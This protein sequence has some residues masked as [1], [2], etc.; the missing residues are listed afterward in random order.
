MHPELGL[1]EEGCGEIYRTEWSSGVAVSCIKH[2]EACNIVKY[3]PFGGQY[4]R[5]FRQLV[6]RSL[7]YTAT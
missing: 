3:Y 7:N 2:D 5:L 1:G 4:M 6:C